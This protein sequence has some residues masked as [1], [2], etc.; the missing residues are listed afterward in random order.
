MDDNNRRDSLGVVRVPLRS[1]PSPTF[2]EGGANRLPCP[3]P[4]RRWLNVRASISMNSSLTSTRTRRL[5]ISIVE[6]KSRLIGPCSRTSRFLRC[7]TLKRG[8]ERRD[9]SAEHT[10]PDECLH[11][12]TPSDIRHLFRTASSRVSRHSRHRSSGFGQGRGMDNG[13]PG[14]RACPLPLGRKYGGGIVRRSP[15]HDRGLVANCDPR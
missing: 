8:W 11:V 7:Q 13:T 5:N 15:C 14:P 3:A 1:A 2:M 9:T 12:E 6:L 4:A 10:K